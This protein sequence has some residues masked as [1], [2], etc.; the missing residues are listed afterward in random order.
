[1]DYTIL[2]MQFGTPPCDTIL[3]MATF[4]TYT[5][6]CRV[7][8]AETETIDRKM[9]MNGYRRDI[10][11]PDVVIINSCA[12]T[13]KAEREVRQT[14]NQLQKKFPKS[15]LILTGCAATRWIQQKDPISLNVQAISN[16]EKMNIPDIL[17]TLII[18]ISNEHSTIEPFSYEKSGRAMIKIQDGCHRFC[19]YCIVP[20]I[21]GKPVSKT[22]KQIIREIQSLESKISDITLAAINTESF[23]RDTG[24]TFTDLLDALLQKTNVQRLSLGS[25]HPWSVTDDFIQLYKKISINERF[26]RFFHIPIQS[27]CQS[28]LTRMNRHYDCKELEK[29]ISKIKDIAPDTFIGTDVITG[30]PGE[31]DEEFSQTQSF[32]TSASIDRF[33]VFRYSSRPGTQ[34]VRMEKNYPPIE[35]EIVKIRSE[36][37][38]A[39]SKEKL[40]TFEKTCIGSTGL[41]LILERKNSSGYA[42]LFSNQLPVHVQTTHMLVPGS[43]KRIRI[44]EIQNLVLLA[45]VEE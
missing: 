8:E 23:G 16:N 25:V 32:L 5:F 10:K 34:S 7:N 45:V 39:L 42:A 38:L 36:K 19:S 30:F 31:T 17:N 21:R 22:I 41:A 27:G 11:N 29:S 40:A 2:T 1:M 14:I 33:H 44:T 6:G 28:T 13:Q 26:V 20:Y 43:I 35:H 3:A 9:Q 37:L 24:E 12:V 15:R 4:L 18:P